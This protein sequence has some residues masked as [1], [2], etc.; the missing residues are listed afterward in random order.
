MMTYLKRYIALLL[1][2][3]TLTQ[4]ELLGIK[5][6]NKPETLPPI[7]QEGKNTFGCYVNGNLFLSRG[8]YLFTP[9]PSLRYDG[10]TLHIYTTNVCDSAG[11]IIQEYINFSIMQEVK[12]G[13]IYQWELYPYEEKK[14]FASF[15][16]QRDVVKL[17]L[18]CYFNAENYDVTGSLNITKINEIQG[19]SFI[20]GTFEATLTS[21]KKVSGCNVSVIKITQG[22]FDLKNNF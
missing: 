10:K 18:D 6:A 21:K 3:G 2:C 14:D 5:P 20:S 15:T 12:E 13:G 16:Y 8:K 17:P 9:N 4:C 22:R 19:N 1:L 7:T 11:I